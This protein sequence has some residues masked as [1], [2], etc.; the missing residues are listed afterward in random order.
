[1]T[2]A[3]KLQVEGFFDPSRLRGNELAPRF[4]QPAVGS[5]AF[6]ARYKAFELFKTAGISPSELSSLSKAI[7]SKGV[8][9]LSAS[10]AAL[11]QR[12]TKIHGS[13]AGGTP[14]SPLLSL[15]EHAP[16]IAL[17]KMPPVASNR[18]YIVRVRIQPEDVGKVNEI[19]KRA[20]QSTEGMAGELEVVVGV[21]LTNGKGAGAPKILSITANPAKGAPLGGWVGPALKWGGRG[22]IFVGAA[23]TVKDVVAA[24]GPHRR[25]TEGRAFGSFAGGTALGAFAAGVCIGLAVTGVGILLCGLGFGILGAVGGGVFGG[26]VGR[27]FD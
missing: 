5:A 19:L 7:E 12:V 1:M 20:G 13:V 25:E 22:L 4:G 18:A 11:L 27:R 26:A 14:A 16:D 17:K 6:D 10:E 8:A 9:G 23:L 15:T 21:D 2:L 3:A 24:E